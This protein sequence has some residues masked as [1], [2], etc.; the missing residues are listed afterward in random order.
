MR[1]L[2]ARGQRSTYRGADTA[3]IGM[4]V[5]GIGAGQIYLG[6][7]GTLKQWD[8]F[9]GPPMPQY[10]YVNQPEPVSPVEQGFAV[11]ITSKSRSDRRGAR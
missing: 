4:P 6:G 5:G 10:D 3:K 8:I 7:D 1:S 9:N 2:A 11:R